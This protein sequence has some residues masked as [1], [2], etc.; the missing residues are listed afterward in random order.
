MHSERELLQRMDHLEKLLVA[1]GVGKKWDKVRRTHQSLLEASFKFR[2]QGDGGRRGGGSRVSHFGDQ[3]R[4]MPEWKK[5]AMAG[6]KMAH[7][8]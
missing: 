7:I 2:T 4:N 6:N 8:W 1:G 5:R 3:D